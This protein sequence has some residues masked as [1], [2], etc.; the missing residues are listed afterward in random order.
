MLGRNLR[1][2]PRQRMHAVTGGATDGKG[3]L[4]LLDIQEFRPCLVEGRAIRGLERLGM[5]KSRIQDHT[6]LHRLLGLPR[7][8]VK[9]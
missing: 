1:R 3:R 4:R 5:E 9:G 6:I 8:L 2:R 7:K